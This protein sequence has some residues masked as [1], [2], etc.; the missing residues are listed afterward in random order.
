VRSHRT[1]DRIAYGRQDASTGN[2][3]A[4]VVLFASGVTNLYQTVDPSTSPGK[5]R[6]EDYGF[7]WYDLANTG[8]AKTG[9]FGFSRHTTNFPRGRAS[10]FTVPTALPVLLSSILPAAYVLGI[11]R[12]RRRARRVDAGLCPAC[13]YDLRASLERY[14]ECGTLIAA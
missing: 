11:A 5:Y 4:Y 7:S 12:R 13:G 1:P 6:P 9:W 14:P 8:R 3:V 2:R 10:G